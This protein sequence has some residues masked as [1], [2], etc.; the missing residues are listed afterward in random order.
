M[1]KF[2]RETTQI[3][4]GIALI[5][6]I[7]HHTIM[8]G[9]WVQTSLISEDIYRF[10]E[11]SSKMCVW[12]FAFLVGY[13][14]YFSNNK[15]FTY[16]FK[17]VLLLIIPFW[18]ILWFIFIPQ[19]YLQ[20]SLDNIFDNGIFN[21]II[22]LI[23][24][25]FGIS[26]SL[27]WY[28][29]FVFFYVLSIF[30]MPFLHKIFEKY[31]KYGWII[32]I[33]SYYALSVAIH[34]L[35][36]WPT[37][38]LVYNLFSY[39][40]LIPIVIVGYMCA[41]WNIVGKIPPLFEGKKKLFVSLL[42]IFTILFIQGIGILSKGFCLQ[43]FYTPILIFAFVGIF[44]S[45]KLPYL[46]KFLRNIG[47]L[48][49]YMWFLHAIFFTVTVNHYTKY[50]VFSSSFNCFF[51]TFFMTFVLTYAISWV[52]KKLLTPIMNKII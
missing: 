17:R 6:M 31:P 45:F 38:L 33:F 1:I 42:A 18:V 8:S 15:T 50:L 21:G 10:I 7:I 46:T 14:F 48:S 43:A 25:M 26:E 51:Y 16:S 40:T 11:K 13:G 19:A 24:N 47:D 34:F 28:S 41:Q 20:G 44:N 52:I 36:F 27:N 29:W 49:M 35:P 39:T 32:T 12:I 2:G 9:D 30:S 22:Y 4:K 37:N 23:Y 5:L 3:L